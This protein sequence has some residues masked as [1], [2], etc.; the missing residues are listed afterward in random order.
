MANIQVYKGVST[1]RRET[2]DGGYIPARGT[3]DGAI[4]SADW[5]DSL[6][7]EGRV[8][9][10]YTGTGATAVAFAGAFDADAGDLA[11]D[12]P[13]GIIA[14]PLYINAVQSTS[15]AGTCECIAVASSTLVAATAGQYTAVTAKNMRIDQPIKSKS[16]CY[17]SVAAAQMTSPY[18]GDYFEFYRSGYP[19]NNV[20]STAPTP[21]YEWSARK[22]GPP[23]IIVDGGSL[24]IYLAAEG[25]TST[26]FITA[27]W[28]ELPES[29]IK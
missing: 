3:R 20:T 11:I 19:T 23:P 9:I 6:V 7:L 17:G 25:A 4:F 24:T 28:A 18:A 21:T 1:V 14:I 5:Y 8:F 22:N 27:I 2:A 16:T 29:F 12:I 13:D 26:G 10:A 15:S